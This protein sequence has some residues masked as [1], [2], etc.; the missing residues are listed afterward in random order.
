MV[1]IKHQSSEVP[2]K[3]TQLSSSYGSVV[4]AEVSE[5]DSTRGQNTDRLEGVGDFNVLPSLWVEDA[6]T[7]LLDTFESKFEIDNIC[8]YDIKSQ[9]SNKV[10]FKYTYFS[11]VSPTACSA[12]ACR[13][14]TF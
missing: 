9:K 7:D 2:R 6:E 1:A 5:H 4:M 8:E 13:N 10:G 14:Q 3:N 11:N 12:I